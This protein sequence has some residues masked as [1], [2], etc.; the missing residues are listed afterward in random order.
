MRV[1][2]MQKIRSNT[3]ADNAQ[4]ERIAAI[5]RKVAIYLTLFI[6][7]FFFLKMLLP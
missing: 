4:Q 3:T 1:K 5:T 7:V 6:V 2:P